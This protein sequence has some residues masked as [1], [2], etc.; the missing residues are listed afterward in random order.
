MF[1]YNKIIDPTL[2]SVLNSSISGVS[3]A[4]CYSVQCKGVTY[5]L[6]YDTIGGTMKVYAFITGYQVDSTSFSVGAPIFGI[7]L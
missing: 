6:N 1:F 2:H 7:G 3:P 4:T 5:T